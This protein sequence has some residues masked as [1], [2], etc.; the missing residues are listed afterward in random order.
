MN[1]TLLI[2]SNIKSYMYQNGLD[3]VQEHLIKVI[4]GKQCRN[5][6][7]YIIQHCNVAM[8]TM[9][10]RFKAHNVDTMLFDIGQ[11]L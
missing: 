8:W 11:N 7:N 2:C 3:V 9:L 5:N 10:T 1:C 6:I 4:R